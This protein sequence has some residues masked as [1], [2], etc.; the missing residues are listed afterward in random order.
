MLDEEDL[1]DLQQCGTENVARVWLI[2]S[3]FSTALQAA[4]AKLQEG[5]LQID[6]F[7]LKDGIDDGNDARG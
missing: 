7:G 4:V 5:K 2:N 3:S 1:L 6:T